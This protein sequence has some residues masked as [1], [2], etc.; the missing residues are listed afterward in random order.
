[1]IIRNI[2]LS[3]ERHATDYETKET[4]CDTEIPKRQLGKPHAL[5]TNGS[6]V[7]SVE[8][9]TGLQMLSGKSLSA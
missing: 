6:K 2:L 9:R 5:R 3:I 4:F 1:M 7:V 8:R